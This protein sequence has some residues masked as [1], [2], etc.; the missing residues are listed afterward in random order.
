MSIIHRMLW[1]ILSVPFALLIQACGTQL[2]APA[3]PSETAVTEAVAPDFTLPSANTAG[4]ISLSS[5][6]GQPVLLYFHMAVG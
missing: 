1:L 3:L 4:D 6:R 2:S 5:Y